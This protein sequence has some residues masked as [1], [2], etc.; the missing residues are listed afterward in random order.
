MKHILY[1]GSM[2]RSRHQLLREAHIPFAVV[3]QQADET[4]CDWRL[5]FLQLLKTIAV[6]KMNHVLLPQ[7]HEKEVRFVLTADTLGCDIDG[8]IHGKPRDREDAVKKIK[9]LRGEGS[10][11]TA[12]CLDKKIW[13]RDSWHVEERILECV[14]TRYIFDMPDIWIEHYLQAVP[15]YLDIGGAITVDGFGAQFLK[16]IEGSYSTILGLPMFEVRTALEK[17]NFFML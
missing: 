15:H 5:P 10:V 4:V 9:A 12:F 11:A 2:S 14:N 7:G 1:I 8:V 13:K 16:E 6:H 3:P 17:L